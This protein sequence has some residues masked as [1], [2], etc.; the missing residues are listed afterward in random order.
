MCDGGGA[1]NKKRSRIRAHSTSSMAMAA[2]GSII[3][4]GRRRRCWRLFCC[5]RIHKPL[6]DGCIGTR[7]IKSLKIIAEMISVCGVSI[8]LHFICEIITLLQSA[9]G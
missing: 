6:W 2:A 5:C 1:D 3:V 7:S 9:F 4:A 8:I